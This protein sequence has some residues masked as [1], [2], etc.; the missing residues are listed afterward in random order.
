MTIITNEWE[1]MRHM[2]YGIT[3]VVVEAG[4]GPVKVVLHFHQQGK[5]DQRPGDT[6]KGMYPGFP[7]G[8]IVRDSTTV[9]P[10]LTSVSASK[11]DEAFGMDERIHS[12]R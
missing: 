11:L 10:S 6:H 7:P 12:R 9:C 4:G 1:G 8:S 3:T 5:D 2:P